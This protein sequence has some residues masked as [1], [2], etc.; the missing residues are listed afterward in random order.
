[1]L[2]LDNEAQKI[3]ACSRGAAKHGVAA[4]RTKQSQIATTL[5]MANGST[6]VCVP[7]I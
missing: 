3:S 2:S 4:L 1:M 7:E 6:Q 5:G